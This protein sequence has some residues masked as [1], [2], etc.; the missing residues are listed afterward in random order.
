MTE[1]KRTGKCSHCRRPVEGLVFVPV[2][3]LRPKRL[4][5]H[6]DEPEPEAFYQSVQEFLQ[7]AT[8]HRTASEAPGPPARPGSPL[9]ALPFEPSMTFA[10]ARPGYVFMLGEH[11]MGYY[12]DGAETSR[13]AATG[14]RPIARP[15]PQPAP[16]GRPPHAAAATAATQSGRREENAEASSECCDLQCRKRCYLLCIYLLFIAASIVMI[17]MSE[18]I[19]QGWYVTEVLC[20]AT[21]EWQCEFYQMATE[22]KGATDV[23]DGLVGTNCTAVE[24][25]IPTFSVGGGSIS[26]RFS[27]SRYQIIEPAGV[28]QCKQ[29][30]ANLTGSVKACYF[31]EDSDTCYAGAGPHDEATA[32]ALL[33]TGI[34]LLVICTPPCIFCFL[35]VLFVD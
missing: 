32:A 12:R 19:K 14:L 7:Q 35:L 17:I 27:C 13:S 20:N 21:N 15:Q 6:Q 33:I 3:P 10:G 18:S 2:T 22:C 25:Y 23:G 24:H 30:A 5:T 8:G 34:V 1:M 11:G 26:E 16:A 28:E 9:S 31:D 29:M 4:K